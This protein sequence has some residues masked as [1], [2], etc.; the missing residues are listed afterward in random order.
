MRRHDGNLIPPRPSAS[1]LRTQ[2]FVPFAWVCVWKCPP[3]RSVEERRFWLRGEL[4]AA[5]FRLYLPAEAD[6]D[7]KPAHRVEGTVRDKTPEERAELQ[8]HFPTPPAAADYLMDTFPIVRRNDEKQYGL[9]SAKGAIL[10]IY[11]AMADA[12]RSGRPY[13]TRLDPP[14]ADPRCW[15]PPRD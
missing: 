14:P 2:C 1:P 12:I 6:G 8:R 5:S 9:Y 10:T 3:S 7:W 4:D 15:H 13:Q 11:D